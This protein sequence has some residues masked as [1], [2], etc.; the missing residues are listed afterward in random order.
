MTVHKKESS[1]LPTLPVC[2]IETKLV[3][4]DAQSQA[5]MYVINSWNEEKSLRPIVA[6]SMTSS[7]DACLDLCVPI[8]LIPGVTVLGFATIAKTKQLEPWSVVPRL[9]IVL[10]ALVH[11][12]LQRSID[13]SFVRPYTFPRFLSI[14]LWEDD[15]GAIF[16]PY[17]K[18]QETAAPFFA[19]VIRVN[20]TVYK[21]YDS[22]S[23]ASAKPSF[24]AMCNFSGL[25]KT[26]IKLLQIT[27]SLYLLC[28]AF[29]AASENIRWGHFKRAINRFKTMHSMGYVHG[30][31][32]Q[33]NMVFAEDNECIL[34]DFDTCKKQPCFYA[35][36]FHSNVDHNIR[37][38]N[39]F[40]HGKMEPIHDWHALGCIMERFKPKV[41]DH[42]MQWLDACDKVKKGMTD[43]VVFDVNLVLEGV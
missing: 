28:V 39:A 12:L 19:R 41:R 40:A 38:P 35:H 1:G 13:Q 26:K 33:S 34:L 2:I 22:S 31:V 8:S 3:I 16:H 36:N 9:F 17:C 23:F 10:R 6:F 5:H 11:T 24:K 42:H 30:D 20:Q 43:D 32:R 15:D 7:G 27:Q 25:D 21:R 37:H 14:G 29:V 18:T 4:E